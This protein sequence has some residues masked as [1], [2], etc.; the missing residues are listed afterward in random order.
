[1]TQLQ[2]DEELV[3]AYV[4]GDE[5]ALAELVARYRDMLERYL[6]STGLQAADAEDVVQLAFAQFAANPPASDKL[7][8]V[9]L[10]TIVD[11]LGR[12]MRAADRRAAR[13]LATAEMELLAEDYQR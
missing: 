13:L 1:M 5:S 12:E 11:R 4:A 2:T 9:C 7:I 8:R 10:F 6:T 3:A